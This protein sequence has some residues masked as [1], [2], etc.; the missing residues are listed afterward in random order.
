M[1]IGPQA[2]L[3]DVDSARRVG[4]RAECNNAWPVI[5]G[6]TRVVREHEDQSLTIN[7]VILRGT[8]ASTHQS[9][10]SLGV[11]EA[12]DSVCNQQ[13]SGCE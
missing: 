2:D 8:T 5:D 10:G 3:P 13:Q 7:R 6:P 12:Q 1:L 9:F 11:P 4:H